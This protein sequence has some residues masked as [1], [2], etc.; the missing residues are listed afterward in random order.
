MYFENHNLHEKM[1]LMLCVHF[2]TL[3]LFLDIQSIFNPKYCNYYASSKN[4]FSSVD[5][6]TYTSNKKP[7]H[8][9]YLLILNISL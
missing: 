6:V 9:S 5:T 4:G 7:V 2:R 8:F 3:N 1:L